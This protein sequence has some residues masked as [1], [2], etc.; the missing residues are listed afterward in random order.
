MPD[1]IN[2]MKLIAYLSG[3]VA[4]IGLALIYLNSAVYNFWLTYG[5]PTQ[6]PDTFLVKSIRHLI[7]SAALFLLSGVSFYLYW[8]LRKSK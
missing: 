3:G 1:K 2:A 5:P 8:K 7:Y 4:C 6:N